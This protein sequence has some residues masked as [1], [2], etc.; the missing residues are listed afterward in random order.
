VKIRFVK[1]HGAANDFVVVDHRAP[2]LPDEAHGL[3]ALL[4][5]LCERRRG[6][7]ADGVLLLERDPE[8]DFA[9]RYFN[10]DGRAAEFCGNGARCLGRLALDLD[11]GT[12]GE[13]RFRTAAGNM[14]ARR[15]DAGIELRFGLVDG[16]GPVETVSV[17]GARV[18]R[19]AD[20]GRRAALR[21]AGG[22]PRPGA[23]RGVGGAIRRHERFA[24]AGT[25]V[26]F[27]ARL[28]PAR[29][30]MRTYE[31]G[32]EAETL[33]C[34]SGAMACA[35]WAMAE[36]DSSPVTVR[37]AGGDDLRVGFTAV[38]ARWDATLTGPA[39]IAYTASGS[40]PC[41]G[42]RAQL[43]ESGGRNVRRSDG[44]D[45]DPV[46][47][48]RGG[49]RRHRPADRVHDRGRRRGPGDLGLDRRS[50]NLFARGA[51]RAVAVCSRAHQGPRAIGRGTGTNN[52]AESITLTRMA[53][54][55]ASRGRCW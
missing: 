23:G 6:V 42:R 53:K 21:R 9:M 47:G 19:T 48:R 11:L 22:T 7:G 45:G 1:M 18:H 43:A 52:T 54:T 15:V 17:A 32:V 38:G 28:G 50:G 41:C 35:L 2:F 36:G 34:G 49:S 37:T 25:N 5:R 46:P 39:E 27:V 10:A 26:D 12:G 4:R 40:S 31:R 33:A 3:E 44:G 24:P 8:L 55:S 51:A 29:V 13:V 30:A 20:H 16:W 14:R